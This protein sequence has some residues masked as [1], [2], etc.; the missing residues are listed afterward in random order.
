[1]IIHLYCIMVFV[2]LILCNGE[3]KFNSQKLLNVTVV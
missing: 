3:T 2:L 1:M